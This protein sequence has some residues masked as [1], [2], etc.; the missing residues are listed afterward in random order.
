MARATTNHRRPEGVPEGAVRVF[1][2]VPD[3]ERQPVGWLVDLMTRKGWKATAIGAQLE[4]NQVAVWAAPP[5]R[6]PEAE[7][8]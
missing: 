8:V 4:G 5:A 2:T 1:R 6:E 7:A 3:G